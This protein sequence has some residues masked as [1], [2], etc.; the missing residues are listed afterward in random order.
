MKVR[1]AEDMDFVKLYGMPAPENWE[2][3]A[4][5]NG[6]LVIGLG[7][8]VKTDTGNWGFFDAIPSAKVPVVIHRLAVRFLSGYRETVKVVCDTSI[9]NAEKWL[10]RLGFEKTD[11]EYGGMN[12]WVRHG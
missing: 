8:V 11:E 3:F 12:V 4:G 10:L 7:G 2:G 6:R 1:P 5:V 9:N